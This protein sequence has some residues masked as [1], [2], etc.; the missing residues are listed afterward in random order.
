MLTHPEFRL[1]LLTYNVNDTD[2]R[3]KILL[4]LSQLIQDQLSPERHSAQSQTLSEE[5]FNLLEALVWDIPL[6]LVVELAIIPCNQALTTV[7]FHNAQPHWFLSRSTRF[8][9][10]LF[11]CRCS[12]YHKLFKR[13]MKI[14]I[15]LFINI[16]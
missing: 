9:A 15:L 14:Q 10:L 3:P 13:L 4:L 12:G 2:H 7:L 5:V 11:S 8:I 16:A 1:S 6:E